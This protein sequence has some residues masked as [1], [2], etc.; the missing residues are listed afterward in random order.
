KGSP[1][2]IGVVYR[3]PNSTPANDLQLFN[4]IKVATKKEVIVMC[5]FNYPD[6]SWEGGVYGS[7]GGE[8]YELLQDCFLHQH[9][10]FPTRGA[11]ILDLVLS[12]SPNIIRNVVSLGKLGTSDQ[13]IVGLNVLWSHF[14]SIST[15]LIPNY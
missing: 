14:V 8:F 9:V 4:V 6:I 3:S 7:K 2:I 10:P 15:E 1:L 13:E 5:D 11:N 12:S